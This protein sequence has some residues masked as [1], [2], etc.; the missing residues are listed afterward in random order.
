MKCI[1][2]IASNTG[3]IFNYP[4]EFQIYRNVQQVHKSEKSKNHFFIV[5]QARPFGNYSQSHICWI[6]LATAVFRL[7]LSQSGNYVYFVKMP[8]ELFSASKN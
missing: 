6:R 4:T 2:L 1:Q 7:D 5:K 8:N 3:K